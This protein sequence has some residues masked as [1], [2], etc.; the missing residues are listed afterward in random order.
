MNVLVTGSTGFIGRALINQ[1]DIHSFK[2]LASVRKQ[3]SLFPSHISQVVGGDILPSTVWKETL[4][5]IDVVIHLAARV[6]IMNDTNTNPL[7]EFR[8]VNTE[9]T[10]NLARQAASAGVRR[11][12]FLSSIKV[13][14]E[15]SNLNYP[16]TSK[17]TYI[18][19]D[20]YGLSKYE[21]EQ[22][23]KKTAEETGME[24]VIIRPPLVYGPNVK[25]NFLSMM[26]W[27]YKGVPLPLGSIHNKRSLVALDNLIDLII[28]CIKHSAA[29]NQT[30]LVSDDEDLSTTGLLERMTKALGR[31]SRLIPIPPRI[32]TLG[33]TL[34]GK[35]DIAQRLC[36][37][38]QV[39]ISHT[40]DTLGWKPPFSTDEAL[41]K[42]ADAYLK[43]LNQKK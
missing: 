3:T 10:L 42:T 13:N 38:L 15:A 28:T 1:L 32:I 30:F 29:A 11:F 27:L 40:K 35:K 34:L 9:G 43:Q 14:G 26:K 19:R 16:F 2:P 7:A 24:V 5:N 33:A 25:A 6:H 21:A 12:I 36:S 31:K 17:D 18:P 4:S 8:K 22:G 20:P 37:S 41:Q 23:L 39:D